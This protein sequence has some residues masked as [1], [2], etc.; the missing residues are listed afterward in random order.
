MFRHHGSDRSDRQNRILAG[1][2]AAIAGFVNSAG[3]VLVGTFTSHVTGNV[4]RLADDVVRG[5]AS[6]AALALSLLIAFFAGAFGA[7][8]L[9]E[10]GA[11]RRRP[12]AYAMALGAE[13]ALLVGF[14]VVAS[15]VPRASPRVLDA[16]AAIL[17]TAMGIQNSLVTRLSGAVVR[18]T[19]LTG[20]FTDLGIEGARWFRWWRSSLASQVN[21]RLSIGEPARERPPS[22]RVLV[23]VMIAAGFGAGAVAGAAA[24]VRLGQT[25]LLVPATAVIATALYAFAT[26]DSGDEAPT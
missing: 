6:A 20:V 7:S 14:T 11:V 1:W 19:H 8:M 24:A 17:A 15:L 10:S 4:G 5:T 16:E 9:L 18:T 12:L 23:L 22:G 3:F 2:L 13:G 25:A 26:R 21:I